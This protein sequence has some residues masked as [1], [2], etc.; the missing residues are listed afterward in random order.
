MIHLFFKKTILIAFFTGVTVSLS[1]AQTWEIYDED[2]TLLKKIENEKIMVL[3]TSLRLS[4]Q[5]GSFNLLGKNYEP[6]VNIHNSEIFQYLEPW[7]IISEDGKLGAY[8]EYGEE[9]FKTEYDDIDTYYNLLLA[10]QGIA[11]FL[12]DRGKREKKSLGSYKSAYIA[13]N[14]QVIAEGAQ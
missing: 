2:F 1:P 12:Y 10:R 6:I 5:G 3:G 13:R 14:G 4:D 7:I 8:H 11:F 9:I